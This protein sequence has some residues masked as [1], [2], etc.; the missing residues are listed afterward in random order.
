[1]MVVKLVK[2]KSGFKQLNATL[3]LSGNNVCVI[4]LFE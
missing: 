3:A 1:M 2:T 4:Y